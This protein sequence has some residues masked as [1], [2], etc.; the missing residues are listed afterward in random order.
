MAQYKTVTLSVEGYA[1]VFAEHEREPTAWHDSEY[2]DPDTARDLR[3]RATMLEDLP[4]SVIDEFNCYEESSLD[5]PL[6]IV[7]SED[8]S[9][10]L[11]RLRELGHEV[12]DQRS[13][14]A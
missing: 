2:D 5:G 14:G 6:G 12:D 8:L 11:A 4:E 9:A 10:L 13:P 1:V 3:Y 7:Q